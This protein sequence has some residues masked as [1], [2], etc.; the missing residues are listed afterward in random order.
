MAP[1]PQMISPTYLPGGYPDP[2]KLPEVSISEWRGFGGQAGIVDKMRL[3]DALVASC[4]SARV[5]A[6]L[7]STL[8]ARAVSTDPADVEVAE[9][10]EAALYGI[11]GGLRN[12]LSTAAQ[13][14]HRGAVYYEPTW[15]KDGEGHV[16]PDR[17]IIVPMRTVFRWNANMA[18]GWDLEQFVMPSAGRWGGWRVT[19][20]A[21]ELL[22]LR[23]IAED[24]DPEPVGGIL[25]SCYGAWYRRQRVWSLRTDGLERAAYGI[26]QIIQGEGADPAQADE[27]QNIAMMMR[28]DPNA[29]Q[30]MPPGWS[31]ALAPWPMATEGMA[32]AIGRD[33]YEIAQAFACQH[34]LTGQ[35][36]GTEALITT[37]IAS[38]FRPAV[39]ADCETISEALMPLVRQIVERN[40]PGRDV[41]ELVWEPP[42]EASM[43]EQV[44]AVQDAAASGLIKDVDGEIE[45]WARDLMQLP[46]M[47]EV[48]EVRGPDADPEDEPEPD[49]PG[50]DDLD[51][52]EA[53][54]PGDVEEVEPDDLP[55]LDEPAAATTDLVDPLLSSAPIAEADAVLA[56][57]SAD[58]MVVGPGRPMAAAERVVRASETVVPLRALQ[59]R[60]AAVLVGWL[61]SVADDYAR[62]VA[63]QAEVAPDQDPTG[64]PVMPGDLW[65]S[66]R[67]VYEDAYDAGKRGASAEWRRI[68]RP[69]AAP[70]VVEDVRERPTIGASACGCGVAGCSDRFRVMLA[71]ASR[72]P[73]AERGAGGAGR[74]GRIDPA[75]IIERWV[76]ET[77]RYAVERI[78]DAARF[79]LSSLGAGGSL[80]GVPFDRVR[81]AVLEAVRAISPRQLGLDAAGPVDTL[82]SLGRMQQQVA[83][84]AT[85]WLYSRSIE[86]NSCQPCI[87]HDLTIVDEASL[88][89]YATPAS[90]CEGGDLCNCLLIALPPDQVPAGARR[91]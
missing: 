38:I 41:P 44:A 34:L 24:D 22:G 40:W 12:W 25:R 56:R 88:D 32:D 49:P 53:P 78:Q 18:G 36:N 85:V 14:S 54:G 61:E 11:R 3:T 7:E 75:T 87:D 21:D 70:A 26:P 82:F 9:G 31:I 89:E 84:G 80:R 20:P 35:S 47:P 30:R 67:S 27:A 46:P 58:V 45:A 71:A 17:M 28:A 63:E 37:Q 69:G 23:Y 16:V 15:R 57:F 2:V 6:V 43:L 81:D 68:Q 66:L 50:G 72:P 86:S 42:S 55:E 60:G 91:A 77:A 73:G 74:V 39:R 8:S 48:A 64:V 76:T 4:A 19:I 62:L 83:D 5:S 52:I 51:P 65:D 10:V 33:G 90:W 13:F 1:R 59:Q 79:A 29:A